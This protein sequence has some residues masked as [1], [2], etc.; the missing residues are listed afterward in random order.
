MKLG[1]FLFEQILYQI[2]FNWIKNIYIKKSYL[3]FYLI[4][5]E[6][7]FNLILNIVYKCNKFFKIFF[8]KDFIFISN[9]KNSLS[10]LIWVLCY[11]K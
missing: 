4:S 1:T 7:L 8:K 6:A 2:L 10:H 9:N 5:I 3:I 11:Y